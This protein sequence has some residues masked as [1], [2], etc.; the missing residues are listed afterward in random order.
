MS[1][2]QRA[3][4]PSVVPLLRWAGSKRQLIP[5][6]RRYWTGQAR[7]YIEPFVG[8]A[9]LFFFLRPRTAL[10][11]DINDELIHAYFEVKYRPRGLSLSLG[12]L[13]R[14][15]KTYLDLRKTDPAE[16]HPTERAARFI[17]LNRFCFNG[18]Y[19][20]NRNGKFNVPYGA[21]GTGSLP[22]RE[23]LA[24]CSRALKGAKLRSCDFGR[25]LEDSKCGDFVYLDPPFSVSER[26]VFNEYQPASFSNTDVKRLRASIERLADCGAHFLLSYVNSDEAEYLQRGFRV[27]RVHVRRNIA[28][29]V[30]K[31]AIS[32]ELLISNFVP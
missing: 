25:L 9:C 15:K 21:T 10:L 11:G 3:C 31:R 12:R 1:P 19:R 4:G 14:S 18:L 29:F 23:H 32:E 17:Y 22:S 27:R 2:T 28:G 30:G 13:R 7:R 26:R 24:K 5:E 6:L 20:T 16:L 8:S